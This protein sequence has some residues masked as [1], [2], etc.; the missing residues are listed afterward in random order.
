MLVMPLPDSATKRFPAESNC[1]ERGSVRLVATNAIRYPEATVGLTEL[2][3]VSVVEQLG[4]CAEVKV[5]KKL[6]AAPSAA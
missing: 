3:G 6:K 2:V 4:T 5:M 1:I